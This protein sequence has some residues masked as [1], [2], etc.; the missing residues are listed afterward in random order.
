[1][2]VRRFPR[3]CYHAAAPLLC[4]SA[5]I[6]LRGC[7]CVTGWRARALASR[8]DAAVGAALALSPYCCRARAPSRY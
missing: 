1:M 8:N 5:D 3:P 4:L 6:T 7:V 2:D